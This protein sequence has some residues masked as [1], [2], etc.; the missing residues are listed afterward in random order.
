MSN[1][2]VS[3]VIP[4][5]NHEK[6]I[7]ETIES[8][9]NQTYQNFEIVI[10]DDGSSDNTVD[11]IKKFSDSRIKLFVFEENKGACSALNNCIINSEGKYVACLNSD[12]VWEPD[13]LEKQVKFLDENPEAAV[14]FSKAEIIDE[15]GK[16]FKDKNHFYYSIFEQGNRNNAEWLRY[17]F[18]E[19]N[20]LCHPSALLRRS[21]HDE[22]GLYN[23]NLAN[24]YD[25]EMW[26][27][28]CLKHDIHILDE[29]LTKFRVRDE[30]ANASSGE[31]PENRIR[32]RFEYKQIIGHYLT[33]DDMDFFLRIFPDA[34]KYGK[35]KPILIPY[36]LG[37]I[38]YSSYID[39]KQ[40]WALETIY[41]LMRSS[42]IADILENDCNFTYSDFINMSSKADVFKV[43]NHEWE[44]IIHEKDDL[45]HKKDDLINEMND[46]IATLEKKEGELSGQ[47]EDL[48]AKIY[49][50]EYKNNYGRSITQKLG[51]KF[52]SLRI[53][54][55]RNSGGIK[56]ALTNIK[57][58][59]AIKK[60]NLLDIGY[61]LNNN[62]DIR[63]SGVDPILHYMYYGFKEGRNPN[64]GFD[65]NHY[66]RTY[67]DVRKSNL[68]PLIH[69]SLYGIKE[70]R[71]TKVEK[72]EISKKLSF[73][74]RKKLE[75][76]YG[77]SV[78]MPTYNRENTIERAIDSVLN[79]T[80]NNYELII[81]DDGSTDNSEKLIHEKYKTYIK[82]GKIKYFKQENGGVSKARN[83]G[84]SEARGSVIA[85]LDSD[86]CWFETY[87]EKMVAALSNHNKNTAYS[88]MEVDDAYRNKKFVRNVKYDRDQL[89]ESNFIDL[90]VFVHKRFLYHQLGGFNESLKRLVD[91]DLVLRYTRLNEPCF[92]DEILAEYFLSNELNNI[93]N[94]VDLDD[95][96]SKVLKLHNAERIK[97]G[98]EKLRI[99]YV[100]WDFPALSQT[101][102]MNELKWLVEN[103]YDVKVFYK[104]RPDKEAKL[105][106]D[107]ESFQIE[108]EFELIEKINEL[109]INMLHTH[110]VY[111][112]CT[113]LTY[114]AA[115]KTGVPFT[116]CAH[117][118]DI[119]HHEND[120]RNKINEIG[121]NEYCK[122]IFIPGKFHYD[123][124]AERGVPEEKLM[125]LR[126]AT[127]YEIYSAINIDS[128][129]FKRKIKNVITIARFIEKKG[130]DTLIDAAKILEKEDLIF[131]IYGYGPLEDDLRKQ[132]KELNLKNVV[133]EGTIKNDEALKNAYHDGDVFV[134][135]CRIAPNGDMD[136]MPTVL[137]EAMAYGIP[138]ITTNVSVI[139]DFVLDN[140]CGFIVDPDNP[141]FL[142]DKIQHVKNMEKN[143]LAA[144]LKHAQKRVQKISSVEET[145]ET[146][147]DIWKNDRIDIFMVTYQRDQ[148]KNLETINEILDRVF[149][150]TTTE[151]DL[152][153]VD[154]NSD[155]EFRKFI[156]NY[157]ELHN[158]IRLI[159]LNENLLCGPASNI[160]LS[161]M[162]NEFAIYICSNEGFVLKHDWERKAL[163]YIKSH[164]NVGIA[165]NFMFSMG[166]YNGRTYKNN[167]CF[168]NFRNKE[169]I[170]GKDNVRFKHVQGGIFILRKETYDQ[171]GGL[172]LLLPQNYMDVEYSYYLESNGWE[173]G[174]IP[175]W[176]SLT[177]KTRPDVYAYLDENTAFVHPLTLDE[178]EQIENNSYRNCNICKMVLDDDICSY[179]KSDSSERAIYRIIG[180]NDK[181]YRSL[182]CTLLL[183]HNSNY[184]TFER[185]FILTN[186]RY[187]TKSIDKNLEDVTKSLKDT[188]VLITNLEL[189]ALNYEKTLAMIIEKLNEEGL[190][191][192]QL[193]NDESLNN[194]IKEF[195][196][197]Q[198][199]TIETVDFVSDKLANNEFLVAEW[200]VYG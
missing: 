126:Q 24:L 121:N 154:N 147:L 96:R 39:F 8:V 89:L 117:A 125:F 17:F 91:W 95:N 28:I 178:V 70:G 114:P 159:F 191:I 41:D 14:V 61:Y 112:A 86:N 88:A 1:S 190:L 35:I 179:C 57:G 50:I 69:Y 42:E 111:P 196:K 192:L 175:E 64:P 136:G 25:L 31:K 153:I 7:S 149:K 142:A 77:V 138:V 170:E 200:N 197:D 158:N 30:G 143:E 130:M 52:P 124:L 167:E 80:F 100:L 55:D 37:R 151:F 53:L 119:F 99:G 54:L 165:G 44:I 76:I 71:E 34:Q 174:E 185:M 135:P 78:I 47:I 173:L 11:I 155:E 18:L 103:N 82:N 160:A 32:T 129:R 163:S 128:P 12:D 60:N 141:A 5:Y 118:V 194:H 84:L 2:L 98:H 134:L 108:D 43:H 49:E 105:D 46:Y 166:F 133:I 38:A 140:Y 116:V 104:L 150:H 6:Y 157:A 21:I 115:E 184:Q 127:K 3:I 120:K 87:L 68:N 48:S 79:Q 188:D 171:C 199:F 148:Y 40:L 183:K 10:T 187:S 27:R 132:I 85:Y 189:N 93:S 72:K 161:T 97:K 33:V 181:I 113:L 73:K 198:K 123:Y 83:K 168:K 56:N 29:K 139:P 169:F 66:L 177:K 63:D 81:V 9:L 193:S 122:R 172:N 131:K 22:I 58:Y 67:S 101:F 36:F 4:S 137:L 145:I 26:V 45:I 20:C 182:K 146:M 94:T 19:G 152:T 62:P 195:L 23:E 162:D 74:K 59:K 51:S 156:L 92:V 65:G 176:V 144:V 15:N 180:K 90:N 109:D 106:F 13:K 75:E 110:F 164:E 107:I 186:R 102:V 16:K